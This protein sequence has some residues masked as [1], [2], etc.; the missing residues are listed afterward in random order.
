MAETK[1][2]RVHHTKREREREREIIK[3]NRMD[4]LKKSPK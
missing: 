4:K 3:E 1:Y 2:K